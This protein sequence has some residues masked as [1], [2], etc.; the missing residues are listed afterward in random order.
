[1][2]KNYCNLILLK[3]QNEAKT[4]KDNYGEQVVAFINSYFEF[5]N[6]EKKH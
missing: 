3:Q 2:I 5:F 1:M 4:L 6:Y